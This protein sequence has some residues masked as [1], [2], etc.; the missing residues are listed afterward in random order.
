MNKSLPLSIV[1]FYSFLICFSQNE[2]D[3]L[4]FSTNSIR[5]TARAQALGGAFSAVGADLTAATLNPAG[6]G[7]YRRSE[8]VISPAIRIIDNEAS[9]LG[10]R[11]NEQDVRFEFPNFGLA[12]TGQLYKG[13]GRNREPV[14]KG[15]KSYTLAFGVNQIENYH[16]TVGASGF[17]NLS[18]ITDFFSELAQGQNINNLTLNSFEELAVS[19]FAID[20]LAGSLTEYFP[21]VNNGNI[22]QNVQ[23]VEEGR[24]NEWFIS[25]AGNFSD[26]FYMGVTIGIQNI[27]Y[28]QRF[29]LIEEDINNVHEEFQNDPNFPLETPF[30]RLEYD[31][32]FT[33]NGTGIN[34]KLGF[35]L[36]P[37]D[38]MRFGLSIQS[39]TYFALQDAFDRRLLTESVFANGPE[40]FEIIADP[41]IFD[42]DLITPY[43][44]TLGGV[45]FL[46]K[47]GFISADVELI[48]YTSARFD[49]D[50]DLNS[51]GFAPFTEQN[52]NIDDLFKLALNYKLGAEAR[53]GVFRVRAGGALQSSPLT[54]EASQ[55]LSFPNTS[56][57]N[58][59]DQFRRNIT[60][61][62]GI[63]Q[64]KYYVDVTFINQQQKDKT[65]IY[66]TEDV[67][68][69]S[70]TIVNTLNTNSLLFSVG[71][72]F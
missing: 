60:F 26:I 37:S 48:D 6:L 61:G 33:T 23:I 43:I 52:Q 70:P 71:F 45:Y 8:F 65:D 39:P 10:T 18:S 41:G 2:V 31:D 12:I 59:L 9:F 3:A 50:A 36:K 55:F 1:F 66:T 20:T 13:Y 49:S 72:N 4:R 24:K 29:F 11:G 34:A 15:L 30:I 5:G 57:I 44:V 40:T 53:F 64:P 68:I 7:L 69:F 38:V 54:D 56:Q 58:S 42:Y 14:D 16:R 63:R 28:E 67:N 19:T 46:G 47:K 32:I 17:N 25:L 35:I 22:Q 62:I 21:A 27:D 51:P